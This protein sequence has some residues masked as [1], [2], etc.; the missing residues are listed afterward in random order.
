MMFL[1]S[2]LFVGMCGGSV[3]QQNGHFEPSLLFHDHK[4]FSLHPKES[5]DDKVYLTV[6]RPHKTLTANILHV[7]ANHTFRFLW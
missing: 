1:F 2:F 7:C 6:D 4:R 3:G 5:Q